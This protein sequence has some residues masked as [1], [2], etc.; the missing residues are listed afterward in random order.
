MAFNEAKCINKFSSVL[1]HD[2]TIKV[3]TTS[4]GSDHCFAN[5]AW[6]QY[7][8]PPASPKHMY[9]CVIFVYVYMLLRV[10]WPM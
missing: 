6:F 4:S 9:M 2:K 10:L 3:A 1:I 8:C 5:L 7:F